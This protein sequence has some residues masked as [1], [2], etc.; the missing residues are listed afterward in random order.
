MI[1]LRSTAEITSAQPAMARKSRASGRFRVRP[2]ATIAAPQTMTAMITARP[3]RRSCA[4]QPVISAPASAPTP[5]AAYRKPTVVAPPRNTLRA[6]AGNRAR[7][8][9]KTMALMSIRYAP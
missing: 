8:M 1:V 3:C 5:G 2:N 6:M 7:G 4:I 9:P